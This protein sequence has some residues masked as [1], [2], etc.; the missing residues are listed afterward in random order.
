MDDQPSQGENNDL[1]TVLE[2]LDIMKGRLVP[3]MV[4]R[5]KV[6][7]LEVLHTLPT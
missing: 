4:S 3:I 7:K 5:V 1:G 2:L 6:R